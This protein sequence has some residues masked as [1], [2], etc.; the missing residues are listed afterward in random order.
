[1]KHKLLSDPVGSANQQDQ[2]TFLH[3][4]PTGFCWHSSD[5]QQRKGVWLLIKA[6]IC[7][8][9]ISN[10]SNDF[11]PRSKVLWSQYEIQ[12]CQAPQCALS[13]TFISALLVVQATFTLAHVLITAM[14]APCSLYHVE[15]H[16]GGQAHD[17]C[18]RVSNIINAFMLSEQSQTGLNLAGVAH[19]AL[20][21]QQFHSQTVGLPGT[22]RGTVLTTDYKTSATP[23]MEKRG[24][25]SSPS[26]YD[27]KKY[28]FETKRNFRPQ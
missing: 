9:I 12:T 26:S 5:S 14:L 13:M 7:S 6:D 28:M 8:H 18:K 4:Y 16:F 17:W 20:A 11:A 21:N 24:F 1:M 25:C 3:G 2:Y 10:A 19:S 23:D 22:S 15:W 27:K